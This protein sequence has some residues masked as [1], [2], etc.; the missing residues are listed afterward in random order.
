MDTSRKT[1]TLIFDDL[2]LKRGFAQIPNVVLRDPRLS[3]NAK[4]VYGLLL[5]YA[6]QDGECFP[7]QCLLADNMGCTKRTIINT[8][9]ELQKYKLIAIK[10]VG[11]GNPNIYHIKKLTAGYL[12]KQFVDRGSNG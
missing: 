6:W 3:G 10:R 5:S 12:P 2:G 1:R 8:L 9:K 7:G 4:A 11:Q